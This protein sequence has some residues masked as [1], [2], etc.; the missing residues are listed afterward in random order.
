MESLKEHWRSLTPE[1][2]K[3]FLSLGV[4][5]IG[6]LVLYL[7]IQA[8]PEDTRR[9]AQTP[10]DVNL[11]T[12]RDPDDLGLDGLAA[13]LRRAEQSIRDVEGQAE[14]QRNAL[15]REIDRLS[16][17]NQGLRRSLDQYARD[18]DENIASISRRSQEALDTIRREV[19]E[20]GNERLVVAPSEPESPTRTPEVDLFE[21]P[22]VVPAIATTAP[23]SADEGELVKVRV[24]GAEEVAFE[25][26]V[27]EEEAVFLPAGSIISGVLINGVDAPTGLQSRRDPMP[28]LV[29]VKRDAIL[30]NRF[31]SDVRECFLIVG[32]TG[33]LSTER[34]FMRGETLSCIRTDGGVIE[35]TVDSYAVGED[36]KVGMRGRLV[37]R[38]GHL[39]AK[40]AAAGFAD[41]LSQIYRPVAVQT[42]N[43]RPTGSDTLFQAP[44]AGEA[45]EAAGYA[46]VGGAMR[47]LA[48][49]YIDLADQIVPFIEIDAGRRI[50]VVLLEGVTLQI[51]V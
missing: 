36:G 28:A 5:V 42:L 37:S 23:G 1:N 24:Y 19:D 34:A 32:T 4:V 26:G 14:E 41:A 30:P 16:N 11:L 3:T 46:G 45:M 39:V 25:E 2:R 18:S 33:D 51:R 50:D 27:N 44:D 13:R 31:K 38:N 21:D 17:E 49:Y 22:D 48:D 10:A 12:G 20:F 43:T 29:R 40:G 9:P 15:Q 8:G 47:R 6:L 7:F 35:V